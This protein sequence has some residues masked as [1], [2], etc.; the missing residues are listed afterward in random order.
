ML[1][2]VL[3]CY[4]FWRGKKQV[5]PKPCIY[6]SFRVIQWR[7]SCDIW[8]LWESMEPPSRRRLEFQVK[9]QRSF[10]GAETASLVRGNCGESRNKSVVALVFLS[11]P[12]CEQW[13][14]LGLMCVGCDTWAVTGDIPN[15]MDCAS[16]VVQ[17]FA[18]M[19]W[20]PSRSLFFTVVRHCRL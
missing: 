17:A 11:S 5:V 14:H 18:T 13:R 15:V 9:N 4:I 7:V 6:K 3:W 16:D 20:I 1:W 8:S 19:K 2:N 10:F 12:R